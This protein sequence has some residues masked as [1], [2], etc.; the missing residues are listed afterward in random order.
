[1]VG[2]LRWGRCAPGARGT[3]AV[4]LG[5]HRKT[6]FEALPNSS[7]IRAAEP[8]YESSRIRYA[9]PEGKRRTPE[10]RRGDA[11]KLSAGDMSACN[12]L[13]FVREFCT[14]FGLE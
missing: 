11:A 10:I 2:A 6:Q 5:R 8:A 3:P 13:G 12:E 14:C 4:H 1:M 9:T 7:G